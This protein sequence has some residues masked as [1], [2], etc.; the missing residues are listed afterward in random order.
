MLIPRPIPLF[1]SE[2]VGK[3][4]RHREK[5]DGL[6][7]ENAGSKERVGKDSE[8]QADR[9]DRWGKR[10]GR[11]VRLAGKGAGK[12]MLPKERLECSV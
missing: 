11:C 1:S 3:K 10:K 8:P 5:T 7:G 4:I 12:V 2:G 6:R 9:G